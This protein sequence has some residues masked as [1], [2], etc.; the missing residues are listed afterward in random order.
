LVLEL[1]VVVTRLPLH[2]AQAPAHD[3]ASAPPLPILYCVSLT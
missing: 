1:P 2:W 3:A